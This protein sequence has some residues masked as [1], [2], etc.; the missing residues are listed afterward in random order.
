MGKINREEHLYEIKKYYRFVIMQVF[1][2]YK[3][4]LSHH[5]CFFG[6]G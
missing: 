4:E 5:F 3:I 6:I 1:S 2:K